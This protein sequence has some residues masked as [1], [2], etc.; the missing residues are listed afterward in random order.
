MFTSAP[1]LM[2]V[3]VT[4]RSPRSTASMRH[5]LATCFPLAPTPCTTTKKKVK[6]VNLKDNL[7]AYSIYSTLCSKLISALVT[8]RKAVDTSDSTPD[9]IALK[10]SSAALRY[11]HIQTNCFLQYLN[12]W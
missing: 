3:S 8:P 6:K 1:D 10:I 4:L 11:E 7:A 12:L 9:V 2:S 5:V